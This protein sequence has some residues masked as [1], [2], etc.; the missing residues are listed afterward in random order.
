MLAAA[1]CI[2]AAVIATV[3]ARSG[4]VVT[5]DVPAAAAAATP[6][7][8][9]AVRRLG[10]VT[11][12]LRATGTGPGRTFTAGEPV[13]LAL[14]SSGDRAIGPVRVVSRAGGRPLAEGAGQ[15]L[16]LRR[17]G[18]EAV[19]PAL[20]GSV[21]GSGSGH[22]HPAPG[23][24]LATTTGA[25]DLWAVK[26]TAGADAVAVDPRGQVLAASYPREGRVEIVDLDRRGAPT[27]VEGLGRPGS[28]GFT[29][30]GRTLWTDD[31][32]GGVRL[33]DVA[34]A[35]DLGALGSG[36]GPEVVAFA[37]SGRTAVVAGSS[38]RGVAVIDVGSGRRLL[39]HPLP[40]PPVGV[41]VAGG[42]TA[43]VGHADGRL[44]LLPLDGRRAAPRTLRVG[45]SG[46]GPAALGVAPDGRT[47]VAALPGA[48]TAVI[49]DARR[50]RVVAR[51]ATG[52]RP[53][54]I[55]FLGGHFA[56]VRNAASPDVTWVDLAD[57]RRAADLRL[58]GAPATSVTALDRGRAVAV[59][60]TE[61]RA[62]ELHVM[63]GRPM[64]MG[65]LPNALSGDVALALPGG[66]R[67]PR[68]S[69]WERSITF[70]RAGRYEVRARMAG[71]GRPA[72]FTI[73]VRAAARGPRVAPMTRIATG[74]VGVPVRIRFR[75]AGARPASAEILAY[76]VSASTG[77]HQQ[78]VAARE[79][80]AGTWS[81]VV[82]PAAPGSYNVRILAEDVGIG[83]GA[84]PGTTLRVR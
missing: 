56:L 49:V 24:G 16:F 13:T 48:D 3:S 72:R 37:P 58:D 23:A 32:A 51:V 82:T 4:D 64:V 43:V 61:R 79:G 12:T 38:P 29:P 69:E 11:L 81:G 15:A 33:V 21:S 14:G 62:F 19:A 26:V 8:P 20:P 10:G 53:S 47:V 52:R 18:G 28:I 67:R 34:T 57:P 73:V 5:A 41:V 71:G 60:P 74:R 68:P 25:S 44:T 83:A 45:P 70:P 46:S 50:A 76:S 66:A 78:R 31:L 84:G 55:A 63:M 9:I 40:A 77:V 65:I 36:T 35:R 17:A 54:E 1:A 59:S 22:A 6:P 7:P 39:T 75:V 30:D 27:R 42:V 80:P 2:G